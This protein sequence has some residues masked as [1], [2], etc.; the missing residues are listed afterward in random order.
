MKSMLNTGQFRNSTAKNSGNLV[1][2]CFRMKSIENRRNKIIRLRDNFIF[3][4]SEGKLR[5]ISYF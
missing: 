4:A 2:E 5:N 1:Q 3:L